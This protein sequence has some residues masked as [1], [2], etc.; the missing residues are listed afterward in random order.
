MAATNPVFKA[1]AFTL[2]TFSMIYTLLISVLIKKKYFLRIISE[3]S[4][5]DCLLPKTQ[6]M[7]LPRLTEHTM[8]LYNNKLFLYGGYG[9]TYAPHL[10][11][12][13]T[14]NAHGRYSI[15]V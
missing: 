12:F 10:Y 3:T 8:V 1:W 7:R 2:A 15:Y 5:W 4:S 6:E 13:D 11:S 14:G 9:S